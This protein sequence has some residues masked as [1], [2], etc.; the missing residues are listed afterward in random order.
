MQVKGFITAEERL[1]EA[2]GIKIL[3]LGPPGIGKTTQLS[4]LPAEETLFLECEAGDLSVIN[5]PVDTI[6]L[7]DWPT[8]RDTAVRIGGPNPSFPPTACYSEAH[9]KAVGGPLPS[10]D[11]YK[12]V[13]LD[14]LTNLARIC[15]RW[16]EN[17]PERSRH[18]ARK[19]FGTL[20]VC[21]HAN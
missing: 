21:W 8:A 20:T 18:Q 11:R 13:F 16:C 3:L 17:Q 10:A 1:K 7:A 12:N 14:S 19:I 4:T 15:F 6:R 5:Y 9:Y 2:R